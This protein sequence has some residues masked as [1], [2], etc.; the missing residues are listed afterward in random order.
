MAGGQEEASAPGTLTIHIMAQD[1]EKTAFM[2]RHALGT[3]CVASGAASASWRARLPVFRARCVSAHLRSVE[4]FGHAGSRAAT[5]RGSAAAPQ[6]RSAAAPQQRREGA[7][8]RQPV[9]HP[10]PCPTRR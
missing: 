1:G 3:A 10:L 8:D 7:H 4:Q 2:A 6:R 5:E 9:R